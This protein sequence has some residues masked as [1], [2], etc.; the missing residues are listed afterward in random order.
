MIRNA[1]SVKSS[2]DVPVSSCR[3]HTDTIM[4]HFLDKAFSAHASVK[5]RLMRAI[6]CEEEIDPASIRRD[7]VC[8]VGRWIHGSGRAKHGA[9]H[10]ANPLFIEFETVHRAF[11]EAAYDAMRSF[12]AGHIEAAQRSVEAGDFQTQSMAIGR[13]IAKMKVSQEF[14]SL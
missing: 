11:H 7:D 3:R 5:Q 13:C 8:V 9:K 14:K 12:K 2:I 10:G 6:R 4:E 1:E